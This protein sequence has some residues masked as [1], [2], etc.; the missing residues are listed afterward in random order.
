MTLNHPQI[1]HSNK[2]E[3]H[4]QHTA[5][6]DKSSEKATF[7]FIFSMLSQFDC[8]AGKMSMLR[9]AIELVTLSKRFT[10]SKNE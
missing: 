8:Y 7:F 5:K 9:S 6:L 1:H 4:T 3:L 2:P 10:K